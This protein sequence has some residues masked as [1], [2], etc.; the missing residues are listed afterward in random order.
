MKG[1]QLV[2]LVFC[3]N[4][5]T[6]LLTAGGI[7][8][9]SNGETNPTSLDVDLDNPD[10]PQISLFDP[11][12]IIAEIVLGVGIATGISLFTGGTGQSGGIYT[13]GL[14]AFYS[15]IFALNLGFL[16]SLGTTIDKSLGVQG[17]VL[18]ATLL[19]NLFNFFILILFIIGMIQSEKGGW[20]SFD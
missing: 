15:V 12:A 17:E 13:W 6:L 8:N 5:A 20:A 16:T 18:S 3:I 7:V 11:G 2:L 19:L 1:V 14:A 9:F 4:I 10:N